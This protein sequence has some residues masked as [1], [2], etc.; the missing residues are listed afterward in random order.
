ML[1]LVATAAAVLYIAD[2]RLSRKSLKRLDRLEVRLMS[3]SDDINA[4]LDAVGVALTEIDTDLH[5]LVQMVQDGT[6]PDGSIAPEQAT[7]IL[8]KA[9]SLSDRATV[10][11][12]IF[13]PPPPSA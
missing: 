8:E 12:G 7:A 10:A 11:A 2:Y 4:K 3:I 6:L 5:T 1:Y 9:T 13:P